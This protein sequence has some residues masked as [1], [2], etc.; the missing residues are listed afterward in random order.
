MIVLDIVLLYIKICMQLL[1]MIQ[2]KLMPKCT[3][4][5]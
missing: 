1:Y 3:H 5:L 4:L 2:Y